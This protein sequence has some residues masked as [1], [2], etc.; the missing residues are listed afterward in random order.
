MQTPKEWS[1][2][3]KNS[4][5]T[6]E[7]LGAAAYS[8]NKR[9]KNCRDQK[10]EYRHR[11]DKYHTAERYEAKEQE[12]YRQKEQLLSVVQPIC[13]H[14]EHQ[15]YEKI[16]HYDYE[17]GFYENLARCLCAGAICWSNSYVN[18]GRRGWYNEWDDCWGESRTYFF[19]ELDTEHEQLRYY[20]YY[21]LEDHTYHH[22]ID[23]KDVEKYQKQYGIEIHHIGFLDTSGHDIADLCSPAFVK[24]LI[25]LIQTRQYT[26]IDNPD[27]QTPMHDDAYTAGT[28]SESQAWS[29]IRSA[30]GFGWSSDLSEYIAPRIQ[31]KL[32]QAWMDSNQEA[33]EKAREE[34]EALE[35]KCIEIHYANRAA[36]LRDRIG[37]LQ[38]QLEALQ[39]HGDALSK[40][41]KRDFWAEIC[42]AEK[43]IRKNM[44]EPKG[45]KKKQ[46]TD[47]VR[48]FLEEKNAPVQVLGVDDLIEQI[49][50]SLGI[51]AEMPLQAENRM[52]MEVRKECEGSIREKYL[53]ELR[54]EIAGIKEQT[55]KLLEPGIVGVKSS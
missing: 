39:K 40:R 42:H 21:A 3:L 2:N 26:Y 23:E 45:P 29:N 34:V 35:K 5:I 30:I 47:F 1:E 12:Y 54:E 38:K 48:W 33:F 27:R 15:G 55:E 44:P 49:A 14:C 19:D 28:I 10:R 51:P 50:A 18:G 4:I 17:Q 24:K 6:E 31:E 53:S 52:R 46:N 16:R 20:L 9:A 41:Y 8:V 13:I 22:P 32:A 43:K 11:Y 7:M 37:K 36:L 25:A